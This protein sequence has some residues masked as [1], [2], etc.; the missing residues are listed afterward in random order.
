MEDWEET[1]GLDSEGA[2]VI[3]GGTLRTAKDGR[4]VEVSNN[5]IRCYNDD[6]NL[7]GFVTN[8]NTSSQ[9]GDWEFWDNGTR[10]FVAYN[11]TLG[12]GVTLM[13][14][15]GANLN[16]GSAGDVLVLEGYINMN[17]T[18]TI[19]GN[20]ISS[21][22]SKTAGNTFGQTEKE[23]LQEVHDKL[24]ELLDAINDN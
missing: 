12:Q 14:D 24:K 15:N 19:N 17:G 13:A 2:G 11:K 23:M 16:I 9:F 5:Q 18:I 20:T 6:G 4:R 22:D 21:F 10:V 7:N 8:N 3:T 1:I